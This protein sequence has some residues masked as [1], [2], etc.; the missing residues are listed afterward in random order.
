M[1]GAFE[2]IVR[3]GGIRG[4]GCT[5]ITQRS[6]VLNNN[7]LMQAEVLIAL[8]TTGPADIEAVDKWI[9]LNATKE[10]RAEFLASVASLKTG[11]AYVWSPAWLEI[12]KKVQIRERRTFNSS[13]TPKVGEKKVEPAK[14][15]DVDLK[16]LSEKMSATIEKVKSEDPKLLRAE[17]VKLR[18]ELEQA[19][20]AIPQ[21]V[22]QVATRVETKIKEVPVVKDAQIEKA[23]KIIADTGE[24]LDKFF[25]K[26]DER[27][28]KLREIRTS[29]CDAVATVKAAQNGQPKAMAARA[30]VGPTPMPSYPQQPQRAY[31]PPAD[32][33]D[34][35]IGKSEMNVLRALYWTQNDKS[36]DMRKLAFLAGYSPNA[37]TL[38]VALSKLRKA[39]Y[40][41]GR[42]L[43]DVGIA[44]VPSN[45]EAKPSGMEL[46]E[47]IR[48]KIGKTENT[49]LDVL[50]ANPERSFR[51]TDLAEATGY[52]PTAST[53]GVAL[54]KLRKYE[55]IE[56]GGSE[57]VRAADIFFE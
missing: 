50:I 47:W 52:S 3:R 10:Q 2:A 16:A 8:Q 53:L 19:Q 43:T 37:S 54:S 51:I 41:D 34:V 7:V 49:V 33:G 39:G 12:F 15:A 45:V 11:E 26:V 57:G 44:A 28:D 20:K 27:L 22:A 48:E 24:L 9:K 13:A 23:N 17:N 18:R 55:A 5:L 40:V 29:F 6:A 25:E 4:L 38:G 35:K 42:T 31:A 36:V 46:R 21:A 30:S 56:G 1:L 14:L 32:A